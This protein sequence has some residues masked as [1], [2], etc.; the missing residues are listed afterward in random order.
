M[1]LRAPLIQWLLAL[2]LS[3]G[4]NAAHATAYSFPSNMPPGC[5]GALGTYTCANLTLLYGDTVSITGASTITLTGQPNLGG[6][7]SINYPTSAASL[8]VIYSGASALTLAQFFNMNGSLTT[9]TAG[10]TVGNN[11][12]IVGAVS[13]AG[14]LTTQNSV[15][16]KGGVTATGNAN[17]GYG[18]AIT[19][20][21]SAASVTDGGNCT[22]GSSSVNG[23][24]TG[25]SSTASSL[26]YGSKVYGSVTTV[27]PLTL[28][29]DTITANVQSSAALQVTTSTI[30]GSATAASITEIT[31][32]SSYGSIAATGGNVS[33]AYGS[34]VTGAITA[35]GTVT[36]V[37]NN[38]GGSVTASG[39]GTST[40]SNTSAISGNLNVRNGTAS[41]SNVTV[42]G[43]ITAV[44]LSD[45]GASTLGPLTTTGNISLGYGTNVTGAVSAGG[46]FNLPGGNNRITGTVTINGT[47]T[48]SWT[49]NNLVTVTGSITTAG[50]L[51]AYDANANSGV[52][53]SG[54]LTYYGTVTGNISATSLTAASGNTLTV[55]G[56]VNVSGA[57]TSS[58]GSNFNGSV[59]A[60][61][62][63]DNGNTS[64]TG[65]LVTTGN[66]TFAYGS[67]F[68]STVTVGGNLSYPY[69]NIA[70]A[71]N[72]T[73][74]IT[75]TGWAAQVQGNVTAG[76]FTDN[77]CGGA[78]YGSIT[79]SS[80]PLNLCSTVWG[81]VINN[82]S[83]G[84]LIN[85]NSSAY[86][87]GCAVTN[88]NASNS[89]N[90]VWNTFSTAVCCYNGSKCLS[91]SS[92]C[93]NIN[94]WWGVFSGNSNNCPI[95]QASN[96]APASF[97]AVATGT[98]A[99]GN[100][101]YT[102]L[103]NV[104]FS[105]DLYAL[106]SSNT[107]VTTYSGPVKVELVNAGSGSCATTGTTCQQYP[108]I[109]TVAAA[110]A[111]SSGKATVSVSAIAN[112][113]KDVCVRMTDT[114]NASV[115]GC[116]K[117]NFSIRPQSF[118]VSA[119]KSDGVTA[120][121]TSSAGASGA[122]TVTAFSGPA[123]P[124]AASQFVIAAASGASNYTGTPSIVTAN[125]SDFLGSPTAVS[126]LLSGSFFA[127]SSGT[128]RGTFTY[129]EVGYVTLGQDAVVDSTF[130]AGSNNQS[131]GDCVS[132][133][134]S[135]VLSS[136]QYGCN[137][138]STASGSW[139]RFIPDHFALSSPSLVNRA[140]IATC[141]AST[142]TY[143]GEDFKTTFT[144]VAQNGGNQITYNYAG[145][146]AKLSALT[147]YA[148]YGFASS[149]GTIGVGAT[150]S[151]TGTWG[152]LGTTNGG[153][154]SITA[155]HALTRA[156]A[157]TTPYSSAA[158]TA[159]PTDSDGV[160]SSSPLALGSSNFYYGRLGLS[161]ATGASASALQLPVQAYFYSSGTYKTW[162]PNSADSCTLIPANA[163]AL[164]RYLD[165]QGNTTSGWTTSVSGGSQ[166]LASGRAQITLAV[167]TVTGTT[168][169][170]SVSV[171]LNLGASTVD[172]SC[173][174]NHPTTSGA[175]L[176]YLR[177]QNGSPQTA[178]CAASSTYSAD[179]S[180][181]ATFGVYTAESSKTLYLREL[182]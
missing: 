104:A 117:G 109:A 85:L 88:T 162:V 155:Y 55:N 16:L 40:V 176:A 158:I 37:N 102:Q 5:L 47:G 148:S 78:Y 119:L 31:G 48:S 69:V 1:K 127:A 173:L 101:L 129:G 39:S 166:T 128:A 46:D 159:S 94:S 97:N 42:G 89:I 25:T 179:P 56:N 44:T 90:A 14:A 114:S 154:A 167:P 65:A 77:G 164:S 123:A 121:A 92:S 153:Q 19:G 63:V 170:G 49:G 126:S 73:G 144:L 62:F 139:G 50:S 36:L 21:L 74:A 149:A 100:H 67:T 17:L 161:S 142:F 8:N 24:I 107:T 105:L 108:A 165:N 11:G 122:P 80:G 140:D 180:A 18:S 150:A 86:V 68:G 98:S 116:S 70:G 124:P 91:A 6:N 182:Y 111:F 120:L 28:S 81:S 75:V 61:S 64:I 34:N 53:V 12:F 136:G 38:V 151:P 23:N 52:Q 60:G 133:S 103:T 29:N 115:Y 32:A 72:V 15:T 4:A 30:S 87:A 118:T 172:S 95:P 71:V 141:S 20:T 131:N 43:T 178:V 147:T 33:L 135:N 145:N 171:A 130:T 58:Y 84:G 82:A 3:L 57:V 125:T 143:M 106:S 146:Y 93:Y 51:V 112:A 134:T 110:Q 169:T 79:V 175:K 7:N 163:V 10:L 83:N 35:T 99:A 132:G 113:Y 157:P 138:G 177:G 76:S 156:T 45:S 66:A 2:T 168:K 59:S 22:Y 96:P 160:T 137:I 41:L 26:G 54:A 27:G 9:T 13:V 152:T 181:T 174:A